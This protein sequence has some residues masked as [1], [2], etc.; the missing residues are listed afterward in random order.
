MPSAALSS[1]TKCLTLLATIG[2]E[3]QWNLRQSSQRH[4]V[5][6]LLSETVNDIPMISQLLSQMGVKLGDL[7]VAKPEIIKDLEQTPFNVFHIPV[8]RNSPFIPAQQEFVVPYAVESVL[9]FGGILP[10]GNLFAVIV[11]A[12][13]PIPLSTAEMFRAIALNVKMAL[14]PSLPGRVFIE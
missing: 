1:E 9:G 2:E 8:V 10:D 6:P 14:L 12:K 3:P 11:F 13:V 5:I 7:A 4:R